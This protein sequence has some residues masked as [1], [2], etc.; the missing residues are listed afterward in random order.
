MEIPLIQ[1]L[2][3][4]PAEKGSCGAPGDC[5]N[6]AVRLLN[7]RETG[8]AIE[9]L[10][11]LIRQFPGTSWEGRASL[12]LGKHYL[13]QGDPLAAPY[14]LNVSTRLPLLGDY[15]HYYLGEALAKRTDANGAATAFDTLVQRYPESVLRPQ[16]LYRA[17]EVWF[18]AEDCL[19]VKERHGRFLAEYSTHALLPAVLLREGD[20]Q[21]RSRETAAAVATYRKIW[22]Q[23]ASSPQA[24]EAASRLHR[25]R[26]SGV[27]L[28]DLTVQD[29]WL[30]ARTLFDAGQY[31]PAAAA[32]EE[33]LGFSQGGPDREATRL[34]L[35]IAR[36]RLKQYQ[37]ARAALAE[38]VRVRTG[39]ASQEAVVWLARV[40]LRQNQDDQ[41]LALAREVE[42][43]LLAGEFKARFLLLLAAQHVDRGRF[44]KAIHVYRQVSEGTAQEG[45]AAEASWRGGWW[46]YKSG[47]HDEAIRSFDHA[48]Q[49]Q[50]GGPY[51]NASLYW[52][53][54]SLEKSGEPKKAVAVAETLCGESSN[55]YYCL[56]ARLRAGWG[57]VVGLNGTAKGLSGASTEVPDP[58]PDAVSEEGHYQRAVELR[59][60][61]WIREA[62]E[63]LAML[64]GR[65][66]G[67]RGG[68]LWLAGMMDAAGDSHR[69]LSLTK[70]YFPEVIDRGGAEVSQ[71]FWELAY[72]GG[73]LPVITGWV[74]TRRPDPFL[75]AAVIRE[76]NVYNP[77]AVS[78]AGAL[79]LMQIM[80]Q[81]GQ[82]VASRLGLL[83]GHTKDRLFEP[84]YNI[85]LG[86][87]Y[88]AHLYEKFDQDLILTIAAYNAGPEAVSKW[89]QQ[90]KGGDTDEFI[91]SIPYTETRQYVKKVM[92]SYWEYKRIYRDTV[93][94]Q[95]LDKPC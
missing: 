63:E 76:E 89:V 4:E 45:L 14:F 15:A 82:Q 91:E 10:Q 29:W 5:L 69:A 58:R 21:H 86:S 46:L 3:A 18:Q 12:L 47:R 75:V 92:R 16:A 7:R 68:I 71:A 26:E 34:K 56:N 24:G 39:T 38:L 59:L 64:T 55:S 8:S 78:S 88:L 74:S 9:L 1:P 27:A 67:D 61:G 57:G 84:C 33:I 37:E 13:E 62:S 90:F 79:G 30:R 81:T 32:L 11:D 40:L 17:V 87:S 31:A 44:D 60:L 20:C 43:G 83:E 73:Y 93:K 28:P 22:T 25:L 52:K 50:P 65:I 66:R 42:G 19:R 80:P 53:A 95:V 51:T 94:S 70:M 35:G 72:P 6:A 49:V 54:R 77:A 41:L 85:R 23:H 2:Q 48:L 36:V